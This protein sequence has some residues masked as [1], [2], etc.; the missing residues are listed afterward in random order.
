MTREM[1]KLLN[2]RGA[3][4][5]LKSSISTETNA[6]QG[7]TLIECLVALVIIALTVGSVT[8]ALVISVATRV[9]SQKVEQAVAVAQAEIDAVRTTLER[10]NYDAASVPQSVA[11]LEDT[12]YSTTTSSVQGYTGPKY[13][14][15]NDASTTY[16]T[17]ATDEVR[18]V[19]VDSDSTPDFGIQV[20]RTPGQLDGDGNP[21][22][23]T[24]GVRV[25]DVRAINAQA[26]GTGNLLT[27][28]ARIGTTGTEGERNERPL[29]TIYTVLAKGDLDESYCR[30]I[31][32]LGS[33]PSTAY[34]DLNCP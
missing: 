3:R 20:F 18:A 32:F 8:P 19:D 15:I 23:F 21:I 24:M 13:S 9:Q 1:Q 31:E 2:Y 4:A 29:A 11:T 34:A 14:V 12:T 10:G 30:Y 28:E 22:A 33:T 17:L 6:E 27:D 25:Y 7:L 26:A 5:L 16:D